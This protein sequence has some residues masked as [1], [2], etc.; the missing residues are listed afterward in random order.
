MKI[1]ENYRDKHKFDRVEDAEENKDQ[2]NLTVC[3]NGEGIPN[4]IKSHLTDPYFT[5]HPTGTGLGLAIVERVIDAHEGYM[6]FE[7]GKKGETQVTLT[8][9]IKHNVHKD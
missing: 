3:D 7:S 6:T 8:I 1:C 5:T 9:P 2:I 4:K